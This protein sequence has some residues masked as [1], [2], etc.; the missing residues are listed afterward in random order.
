MAGLPLVSVLIPA[1]DAEPWLAEAIES[2]L[3]QT[4]PRLEVVVVDDGSSDGTNQVLREF[5]E[6]IRWE[7]APHRGAGAA[8]ARLLELAAG[9]WLQYLDA[10]DLLLPGKIERQ[11]AA[12]GAADLVVSGYLDAN[13]MA[14]RSPHGDDPWVCFFEGRMGTTTS[15]LFR[16]EALVRCGGWDVTRLAA[17]EQ[18]LVQRLLASG[19]RV[20]FVPEPLCVK[21]RVNPDSLWRSIWRDD[22]KAAREANVSAVAAGVRHLRDGVALGP[23]REAAAGAR[24][25]LMA[26]SAW[27]RGAGGWD[28]VLGEAEALGLSERALL[29]QAGAVYR[30]VYRGAGFEAAER[31]AES[32]PRVRR[33]LRRQGRGLRRV[34]GRAEAALRSLH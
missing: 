14:Q 24:F 11:L 15:H 2:A 16:R 10:D 9:E 18:E 5:G 12:A 21:R 34:R 7:R 3:A 20:A 32:G 33:W 1:W 28:E 6:R 17:Q 27:R 23:A 19:A 30:G 8:R 31:V 26:R 25:L 29:S 22:P 13:G 4:H